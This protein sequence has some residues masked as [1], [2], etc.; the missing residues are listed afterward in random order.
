MTTHDIELDKDD[1]WWI[2]RCDCGW[3]SPEC[4][5]VSTAASVWGGHLIDV[6]TGNYK[7]A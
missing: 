4:P 6:I 3:F 2:A 7:D 5:D 1:G